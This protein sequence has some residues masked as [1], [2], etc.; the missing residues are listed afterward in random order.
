MDTLA[1]GLW[2]N[3]IFQRRRPYGRWW[4]IF[5]GVAPDLF[6]FGPFFLTRLLR[7]LWPLVRPELD[8][9]PFYVSILYN[10]TH[11][12][13][14]FLA[15]F[16]GVALW[17]VGRVWWPLGAWGLHILIDIGTHTDEFFPTPFLF[18]LSS[19]KFSGISWADKTFMA[20]NYFV[21]IILYVVLIFYRRRVKNSTALKLDNN[22]D[23]DKI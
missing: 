4:P 18:P 17:R 21:L 19:W 12:L 23:D 3:I 16:V 14:I 2:T 22:I 5:F 1:H 10:Y 20:V 7:G 8:I 6:S 9:I 13:I 11:S 15:I